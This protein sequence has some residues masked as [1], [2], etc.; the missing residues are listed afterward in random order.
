MVPPRTLLTP[1]SPRRFRIYSKQSALESLAVSFCSP[2]PG[3]RTLPEPPRAVQGLG[4]C[5][6]QTPLP[7]AVLAA[8]PSEDA[9]AVDHHAHH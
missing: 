1:G 2:C 3:H 9:A 5:L 6:T 7:T 4:C 8:G